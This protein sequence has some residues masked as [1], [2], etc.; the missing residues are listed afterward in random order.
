MEEFDQQNE[1]V[2]KKF[3]RI[4]KWNKK[5]WMR[6]VEIRMMILDRSKVTRWEEEEE[7]LVPEKKDRHANNWKSFNGR[8]RRMT[9]WKWKSCSLPNITH[10]QYSPAGRCKVKLY[11][12]DTDVAEDFS[13]NDERNVLT[14]YMFLLNT[15]A[16][17]ILPSLANCIQSITT[18]SYLV[19]KYRNTHTNLLQSIIQ[20]HFSILFWHG[21]NKPEAPRCED[22]LSQIHPSAAP[23]QHLSLLE[24]ANK[25]Q[26]VS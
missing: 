10:Q 1:G 8:K 16:G 14:C 2:G 7:E 12:D 22:T 21:L 24:P 3:T 23:S 17:P 18:I 26:P 6:D 4:M 13:L 11:P 9:Y 15:K 5:I 20:N 25:S 19:N